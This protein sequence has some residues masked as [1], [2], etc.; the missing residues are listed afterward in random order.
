MNKKCDYD[1]IYIESGHAAFDGAKNLCKQG[2]KI[3]FVEAI[4][5]GGTCTNWGCNA[6]IGFTNH[7]VK[8]STAYKRYC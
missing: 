8:N 6:N 2:F 3:A 7:F 5:V 4:A 1:V